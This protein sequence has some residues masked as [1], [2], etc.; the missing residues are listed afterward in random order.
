[1]KPY[2]LPYPQNASTLV[3]QWAPCQCWGM[4]PDKGAGT[5]LK[6]LFPLGSNLITGK[7]FSF[8]QRIGYTLFVYSFLSLM[9]VSYL[10]WQENVHEFHSRQ[11]FFTFPRCLLLK[12]KKTPKSASYSIIEK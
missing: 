12:E 6:H 7:C 5:E 1:M 3:F 4:L 10:A 2:R 11:A 9:S 8:S